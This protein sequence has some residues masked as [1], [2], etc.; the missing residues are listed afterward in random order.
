M[1]EN[2]AKIKKAYG[3]KGTNTEPINGASKALWERLLAIINICWQIGC[4]PAA[5]NMVII[6]PTYKKGERNNCQNY[7]AINF[8]NTCHKVQAEIKTND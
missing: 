6:V 3:S 4:I 5:W 2:N 8:L 1:S 7:N